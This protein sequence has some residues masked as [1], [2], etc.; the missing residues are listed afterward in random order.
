MNRKSQ[1]QTN[2]TV[3]TRSSGVKNQTKPTN[4][5][6]NKQPAK[7]TVPDERPALVAKQPT[8]TTSC[9][10]SS[11]PAPV[12][13]KNNAWCGIGSLSREARRIRSGSLASLL[14]GRTTS[15]KHGEER[16]TVQEIIH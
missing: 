6:A 16:A 13:R 4:Q 2:T 11:I 8:T 5:R 9:M 12:A 1:R 14:R 7:A 10:D 15:K 3:G